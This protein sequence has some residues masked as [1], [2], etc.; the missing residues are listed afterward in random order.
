MQPPAPS[1][2]L[3]VDVGKAAHDAVAVDAAGAAVHRAAAANDEPA[4]RALVAWARARQAA[5]VVD[6][7]GGAAGPVLALCWEAGVPAAYLRGTAVAR[8][9]EFYPGEAKTDPKD[10]FV[11][12]DVARAHPGRLV[13]LRPTPEARAELE[14]RLGHDEDLRADANRLAN[15]LRGC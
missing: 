13:W 8:A 4:L 7:P 3:G 11:L 15:R 1:L 2:F 5:L 9:R 6:R 14:P 10:A 12:A